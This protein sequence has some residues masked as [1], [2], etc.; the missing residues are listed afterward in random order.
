MYAGLGVKQNM[1]ES[2]DLYTERLKQLVDVAH[3]AH[4]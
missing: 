4:G 2:A 1:H 3:Y